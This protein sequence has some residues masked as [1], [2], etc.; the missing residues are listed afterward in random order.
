M[1][2]AEFDPPQPSDTSYEA[3]AEPPSHH[4]WLDLNIAVSIA[5]YFTKCRI[6][7]AKKGNIAPEFKKVKVF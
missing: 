4:W 6:L 1:P 3:D 2:Q 5:A 7:E